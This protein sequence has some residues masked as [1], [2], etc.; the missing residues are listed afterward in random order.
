LMEVSTGRAPVT[1]PITMQDI[2]PYG[3]GVDHLNSI[4]QPATATAAP[5]VGVAICA[6]TAVPGRATGVGFAVGGNPAWCGA[7]PELGARHAVA[8]AARNLAC[9]GAR[10]WALTDCLNFGHP[11]DAAVMGDLE[12]TL[13]GLAVS[14]EALGGL[15]SPGS[16]LPYVSGNV[17]LYNQVGANA[18][19]PSPIVMAAGVIHDVTTAVGIALRQPGHF[20]VLAG[21]ART[22]LTGSLY[23]REVLGA[24]GSAPPR[25]DLSREARLQ[26]LAVLAAEGR[27]VTAA[28]DVSDGG[29]VTALAEMMLARAP[30][31]PLGAEVDLA[32]LEA[33]P[34]VALF[35][36]EPAILWEVPPD[37]ATR[38]FAAAR[39]R[40]LAAWPIG[41]V[42][43]HD[44]LRVLL[45]GGARESWP[46]AALREAVRSPLP[47]LWNEE[48]S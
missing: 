44:E 45:P 31:S 12:A 17:S 27:W 16:P 23:A 22:T 9:A 28:H 40:G 7:D 10:P 25:L 11:Q 20:L 6:E 14:A 41:T 34:E 39:E 29:L 2:T 26:E 36:E 37:G 24:R 35:S 1:F 43:A 32:V 42:A 3:N 15:A 30:E 8:E 38:L 21:E 33:D 19:P 46:V 48:V 5:V 18:I 47:R 13:E 4:L